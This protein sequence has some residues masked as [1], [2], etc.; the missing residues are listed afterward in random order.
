MT[1]ELPG[2]HPI[3]IN[4]EVIPKKPR[5]MP[6]HW[7]AYFFYNWTRKPKVIAKQRELKF[8]SDSMQWS[9]KHDLYPE[10]L[11]KAPGCEMCA[12]GYAALQPQIFM[13]QIELILKRMKCSSHHKLFE[14][15]Y[16][17]HAIKFR[18]S[19]RIAAWINGFG[20]TL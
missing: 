6:W 11:K 3:L 13:S 19:E 4:G 2:I 18:E 20:K 17:V 12:D 1:E 14:T 7:V 10:L 16:Q 5:V 9:L 15:F 8:L